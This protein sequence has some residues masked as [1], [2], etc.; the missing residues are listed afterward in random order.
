MNDTET[1]IRT[2]DMFS[3]A[4]GF[5]SGLEKAGG[6]S[7]AG[8]C[9]IDKYAQRAYRALYDTEG[10]YFCDDATKI[11]PDEIPDFDLITAGFPCQPFSILGKGLGLEDDRGT[12]FNEIARIARARHPAFVLMENVPGLA[13]HDGGR[14]LW[15]VL[16]SI[17]GLGYTLEYRILD[18]YDF[19][20]PQQRKRLYIIG[21]LDSRCAG[22]I[23]YFGSGCDEGDKQFN[24]KRTDDGGDGPDIFRTSRHSDAAMFFID[25]DR[26]ARITD[27]A[28][29]ITTR[30]M[31]TIG[32]H[33]AERSGAFAENADAPQAVISA[34]R[35]HTWQNG[36]RVRGPDE[37]MYTLTVTDRHGV[38]HNGRIRMLMPI[39]YWRLQGYSDDQF[40]KAQSLGISDTQLYKMAGNSVTVDVVAAI[41]RRIREVSRELNLFAYDGN[42]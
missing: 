12:L 34:N 24:F 27:H 17:H 5:R 9:E 39:E 30:Q 2:F 31:R 11:I 25:M 19:G 29:C 20:I 14:S 16:D 28:R 6:F 38:L 37:P 33:K 36:S 35:N 3:G 32:N 7:F 4:G 8:W 15:S 18:S 22:K 21:Y 10:E 42:S 40:Y 41:G 23:L 13:Y 26:D 1:T